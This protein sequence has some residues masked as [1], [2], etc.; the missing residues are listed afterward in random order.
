ML[1]T[2][3]P[4]V[5][6]HASGVDPPQRWAIVSTSARRVASRAQLTCGA[7]ACRQGVAM[8][9]EQIR[10][11]F[12]GL[13]ANKLRS[14]LTMLGMTIGVGVGDR[15]DLRRDRLLARGAAADPGAGHKRA[16]RHARVPARRACRPRRRRSRSQAA[17]ALQNPAPRRRCRA[18]PGDQRQQ[19]DARP[20]R[21]ELLA[22]DLH[23]HHPAYL[24]AH[25]YDIAQGTLADQR[26]R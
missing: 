18:S 3:E 9:R 22:L 25:N 7:G 1:I 2:H 13:L 26:P 19:R 23:R 21:H 24:T 14:A 10:I 12:A 15:A 5:A 8:I 4:E 20:Q 16:A 17:Q 11:A 6:A